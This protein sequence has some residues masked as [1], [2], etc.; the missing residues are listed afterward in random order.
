MYGTFLTVPTLQA[1]NCVVWHQH[2]LFIYLLLL[3]FGLLILHTMRMYKLSV[4]KL[5]FCVFVLKYES[6]ILW[7][8]WLCTGQLNSQ[9]IYVKCSKT[10]HILTIVQLFLWMVHM[11]LHVLCMIERTWLAVN[12]QLDSKKLK[13]M[14]KGTMCYEDSLFA[15]Q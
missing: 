10:V 6:E 15:M 3:S 4:L 11:Y 2:Y 5:L 14:K 12:S 7:K 8:W 13:P 1:A 9:L